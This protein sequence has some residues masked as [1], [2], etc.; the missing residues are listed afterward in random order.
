MITTGHITVVN[1]DE[2]SGVLTFDIDKKGIEMLCGA[3]LNT[4]LREYC[5]SILETETNDV[6]T[7]EKERHEH[8]DKP[9][10]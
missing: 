7:E 2:D 1:Y 3:A 10:S 4:M 8:G 5:E 9:E 6:S